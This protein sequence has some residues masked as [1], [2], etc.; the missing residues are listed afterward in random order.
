MKLCHVTIQTA[1]FEDELDFYTRYAG[2]AIQRDMRPMGRN[3]VFLANEKGDTEIEII[4][5][6]D[7]AD[8][9]NVNLSIGFAAGDLDALHAELIEDGLQPTDFVSPMPSVRFFFV[10]DPAGVNVQFI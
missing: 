4:Q 5:N 10:R 6:A 1:R 7:A 3:M 2:L 8:S 9:G